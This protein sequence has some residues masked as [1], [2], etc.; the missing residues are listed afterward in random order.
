MDE[1]VETFGIGNDALEILPFAA[2]EFAA[3]VFEQDFS[4]TT[5]RAKWRA[6]LTEVRIWLADWQAARERAQRIELQQ[7]ALASER[8][9]ATLAAY[10]GGRSELTP[11]LEARRAHVETRL[12]LLLARTEAGR[13]W[14]QLNFLVPADS[15]QE[16][17]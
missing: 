2:F 7:V 12:A 13:A 8:L 11:V 1:G 6:H 16:R 4:V 9:K 17:S 14:A 3:G 5:H 10:A 15:H